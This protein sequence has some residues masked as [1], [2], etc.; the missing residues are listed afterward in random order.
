MTT[1]Y[2]LYIHLHSYWHAGSGVGDGPGADA[3]V[4]KTPGELPY[5]PGRTVRGLIRDAMH[6][7]E[8][9]GQLDEHHKKI[10]YLIGEEAPQLPQLTD[11]LFGDD[12]S[13][14]SEKQESA[15]AAQSKH[16]YNTYEGIIDIRDARLGDTDELRK[17]WEEWGRRLKSSKN[18]D[19][20]Q[21]LAKRSL[22]HSFSSTALI[23]DIRI[24]LPHTL[25]TIE[26]TV[27]VKLCAPIT[28]AMSY[29]SK[30]QTHIAKDLSTT[31]KQQVLQCFVEAL[32]HSL[33]LLRTLG[34]HRNRGLG[35]CS[36]SMETR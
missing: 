8:E 14:T 23:P 28:F 29:S 19:R 17:Q 6:T 35:R 22:Y 18:A 24:A 9:M 30:L 21:L 3:L 25:R 2:K 7:T 27:P 15:V 36:V 1:Q 32:E 5:L 34:S 31:Q 13:R 33:P 4:V 12:L 11:L 20:D 26:V 16:R 10:A